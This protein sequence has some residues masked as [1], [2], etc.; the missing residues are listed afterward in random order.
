MGPVPRNEALKP[1]VD[2][3]PGA[4]IESSKKSEVLS[5]KNTKVI[6]DPSDFSSWTG[7]VLC[8]ALLT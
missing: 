3:K 1:I 5:S 7:A 8:W 2:I 4:P 6:Q